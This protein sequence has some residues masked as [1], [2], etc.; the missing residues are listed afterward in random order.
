MHKIVKKMRTLR[1]YVDSKLSRSLLAVVFAYVATRALALQVSADAFTDEVGES[2]DSNMFANIVNGFIAPLQGFG[3]AV[4]VVCMIVTGIKL[5]TSSMFGDPRGRMEAIK[6]VFFI[7]IG[8][9]V[10]IHAKQIVAFAAKIT[11]G[12]S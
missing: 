11:M 12:N 6:S 9:A 7:V 8:G 10:I 5:G 4:L 2:G 1:A 3:A